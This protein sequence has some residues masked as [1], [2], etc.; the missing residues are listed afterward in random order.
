MALLSLGEEAD[1]AGR[2]GGVS[3]KGKRKRTVKS[4][5]AT[6][7][8]RRFL[9]VSFLVFGVGNVSAQSFEKY[10]ER[11]LS[12]FQGYKN[13]EKQKFQ[14]YRDKV[15]HEFAE[16][17]RLAWPGHKVRPAE[18]IPPRPE[19]PKPVVIDPDTGPSNDLIP[20]DSILTG[21]SVD[22]IVP[23]KV[24]VPVPEPSVRTSF[25]FSFYGTPCTVGLEEWHRFVLTGVNENQV[26]DA[27]RKLSAEEYLTVVAECL[28]WRDKLRL[29]DWG[30]VRL[31]ERM[32][33][34][35]FP[36]DKRN[37]ACL[38]QMYILTQSGYKVRIA[39]A[40]D[41]L[42]LLLPSKGDIYGYVYLNIGGCKYYVVDPAVQQKTL[43]VFDREFP[44]ERFVSLRIFQEP[45]LA[46]H[47]VSTRRLTAGRYPDLSVNVSTN[48]NLIDFYNDY[49]QG[50]W[51]VYV[52][53]ALSELVKRQLYPV[54]QKNIAG[55]SRAE[56]ANVLI[57][58]VQ[59][60]FDYQTD[61]E[62]FGRERPLFADETI[63]YPFSDCEDRAILYSV[64]VRDLLGL[65]VV[66]LH[67]PDHLATAVCFC[68]DTPGDYMMIDGGKYVVCDPTY[69]GATV[70]QTMPQYKQVPAEVIKI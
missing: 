13:E 38:L 62:Q 29:C 1:G 31:L 42:V 30:Y 39:R 2:A 18:P 28:A 20:F 52:Q 47:E 27:W 67:Y 32:T 49:P 54:L 25:A 44:E 70:G 33:T 36:D 64:L 21:P 35:F 11:T 14:A 9:F 24:F 63:F 48:R 26:A 8:F 40:D 5:C 22:P 51:N 50:D 17:M 10:R 12:G 34:A 68:D 56:A 4:N 46:L 69:I 58:W 3:C 23:P 43:Y 55:R 16:Y 60:A 45:L 61:D 7:M 59:T 37:E 41:R 65:E 66:L 53:A 57:N 19:P 15:N 6:R